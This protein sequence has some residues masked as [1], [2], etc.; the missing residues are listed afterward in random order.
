MPQKYDLATSERE[1]Y[2]E[3]V[4]DDVEENTNV[5]LYHD[6]FIEMQNMEKCN[7]ISYLLTSLDNDVVC[8]ETNAESIIEIQR[9]SKSSISNSPS[10]SY[11][12]TNKNK[13]HNVGTF[14]PPSSNKTGFLIF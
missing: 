8:K 10:E 4:Q 11:E 9:K 7:K 14:V 1:M 6:S 3:N 5:S 12:R 2:S 13:Q